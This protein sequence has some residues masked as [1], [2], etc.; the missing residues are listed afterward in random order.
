MKKIYL[1]GAGR[2]GHAQGYRIAA[3]SLLPDW[4]ALDPFKGRTINSKCDLYTPHEI[5]TRD[6]RMIAN[7]DCVLAEMILPDYNYIGTSMEI[8]YASKILGLPVVVYTDKYQHHYW[9]RD[10]TVANFPTLKECCD[11]VNTFWG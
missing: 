2:D 9:L 11:Y 8:F 7:A 6:L 10:L 5:V 1:A 4:Q 3:K